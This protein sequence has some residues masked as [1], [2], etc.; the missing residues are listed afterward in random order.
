MY[1]FAGRLRRA[2]GASAAGREMETRVPGFCSGYGY[3][4]GYLYG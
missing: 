2:A 3:V 4:R 1:R